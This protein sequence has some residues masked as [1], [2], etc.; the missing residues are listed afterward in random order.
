MFLS[1]RFVEHLFLM[2]QFFNIVFGFLQNGN[3]RLRF[4][5]HLLRF[6]RFDANL[7][8]E[9]AELV[10]PLELFFLVMSLNLLKIQSLSVFSRINPCG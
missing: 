5:A 7:L 4:D 2:K 1:Q 10:R 8:F 3:L 9:R 6:G